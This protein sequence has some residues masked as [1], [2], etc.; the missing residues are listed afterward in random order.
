MT[1]P[2]AQALGQVSRRIDLG[3]DRAQPL[4]QG[5]WPVLEHSRVISGIGHHVLDV[6]TRLIKGNRFGENCPFDRSRQ[7]RTPAT[8][9]AWT[10]IVGGC[11]QR[12]GTIQ[13]A[14]YHVEL[15]GAE[16]QIGTD[17]IDLILCEL[18]HA[19][20]LGDIFGGRWHQLHQAGG[21]DVG[22][23]ILDKP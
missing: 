23:G 13:I 2:Q 3:S 19:N 18:H 12:L 5:L 22:L 7:G 1:Q 11:G 17:I 8:R 16:L 10:S 21:T 14:Q 4:F 6:A 15:I 9:A 20:F